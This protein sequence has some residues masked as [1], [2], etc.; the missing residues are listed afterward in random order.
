MRESVE[1]A[2]ALRSSSSRRRLPQ[3]GLPMPE[4]IRAVFAAAP[5]AVLK[6]GIVARRL[7]VAWH[8]LDLCVTRMVLAGELIDLAEGLALATPEMKARAR[9]QAERAEALRNQ[10]QRSQADYEA[11]IAETA[12]R[13]VERAKVLRGFGAGGRAVALLQVAAA[14]APLPA[15]SENLGVLAALFAEQAGSYRDIAPSEAKRIALASG[16]N[17]EGLP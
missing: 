7:G 8:D 10:A 16:W 17:G 1:T 5:G 2:G 12:R 15:V 4:R 9:A 6:P 11:V 3:R 14:R 13:I